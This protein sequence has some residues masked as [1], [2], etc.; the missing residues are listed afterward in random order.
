M[1]ENALDSQVL[2]MKDGEAIVSDAMTYQDAR[3]LAESLEKLEGH[4]VL[5]V[6]SVAGAAAYMRQKDEGL[7]RVKWMSQNDRDRHYSM[8]YNYD[9]AV[10]RAKKL[11]AHQGIVSAVVVPASEYESSDNVDG[12]EKGETFP[13][14]AYK[15]AHRDVEDEVR[16]SLD[17]PDGLKLRE[18]TYD[19][20]DEPRTVAQPVNEPDGYAATSSN[21]GHRMQALDFA[22][23]LHGGN[24]VSSEELV[25]DAQ[26]ILKFLEG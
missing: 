22:L 12:L 26:T 9:E 6:M 4:E 11:G 19:V 20:D 5:A 7:F 13:I 14:E 23:R 18:V 1:S 2:Y 24:S 15:K 16:D 25:A 8:P 3:D 17:S 10:R 21:I